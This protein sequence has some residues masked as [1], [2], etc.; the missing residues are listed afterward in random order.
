MRSIAHAL[1]ALSL[2]W[3]AFQA[4]GPFW[5]E[6]QGVLGILLITVLTRTVSAEAALSALGLGVG[7]AAPCMILLGHG[8]A[9]IGIDPGDSPANWTIVAVLEELVKFLPVLFLSARLWRTFRVTFN[10]SDWLLL[11][12][13]AG[14]GFALIE[15]TLLIQESPG[16]ASDMRLHYGPHLGDWYLVP[17]AWGA[18][19]YV[20]HG[21]A[22]GFIA[23]GI[24]LSLWLR[25]SGTKMPFPFWAPGVAACGWIVVEHALA[26]LHVS[27]G[28][29][30]TFILGN[31]R[32][33]PWFYLA[34][35]ATVIVIDGRR[36]RA[37]L[38]RSPM[39]RKRL[40]MLKAALL[41]TKPPV[42]KS[43]VAVARML[44]SQVR[45]LNAAA[46]FVDQKG[47]RG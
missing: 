38:G 42:P 33:T 24:G 15:N 17:G 2:A 14:T 31:G 4:P 11:G 46:W 30:A 26:N 36:A 34:L 22:T 41:R 12:F 40:G 20:G 28:S 9:A 18:A 1:L 6:I 3:L 8:L 16:V 21:A 32:L 37:S 19:G 25:R 47:S 27:T 45:L 43:R 10:P 29:D 39:L 35:A 7:V 13:A 23:G 5:V 44:A